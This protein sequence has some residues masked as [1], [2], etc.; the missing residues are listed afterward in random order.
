[1]GKEVTPLPIGVHFGMVNSIAA[2]SFTGSG[3]RVRRVEQQ[4]LFAHWNSSHPD[5]QVE[6]GSF[7]IEVN[8]MTGAPVELLQWLTQ[9]DQ[10][11]VRVL[12][13]QE[14]R[15]VSTTNNMGW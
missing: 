15:R 6:D 1:M 13:P 11:R 14:V 2:G 8:G 4:G 7:I 9:E 3:L 5:L 12:P 10:L